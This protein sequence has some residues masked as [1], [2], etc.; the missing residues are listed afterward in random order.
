MV[1][2]VWR[3]AISVTGSMIID[4]AYGIRAE[5][6]GD[7]FIGV[8]DKALRE[9]EKCTNFSVIDVLPWGKYV[10]GPTVPVPV[11]VPIARRLSFVVSDV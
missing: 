1:G 5:P 2:L 8:A 6:E 9:A 11:P 4:L 7:E 3:G 10:S